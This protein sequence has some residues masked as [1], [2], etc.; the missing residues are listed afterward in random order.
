MNRGYDYSF[1]KPSP[2]LVTAIHA[3]HRVREEL[4]PIMSISEKDRLFEE[5]AAT[6]KIIGA[7]PN[8]IWG[9]DS[10]AEYDLNRPAALA[11]PLTA[12]RFWGVDVYRTAPG[13]QARRRSLAKYRAFYRFV[14]M[15]V[16]TLIGQFGCCIVHDIHS[17]NRS[18][19]IARGFAEP[20]V[21]NVGTT[22]AQRDKYGVQI[23]A[24]IDALSRIVIPGV[25]VTVAENEVFKGSGEFG[26]RLSALDDR[27]LVLS[28]EIAKVYMNEHTGELY[29]DRIDALSGQLAQFHL[30][31]SPA[32]CR[33]GE[34]NLSANR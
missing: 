23:D 25:A 18:R 24:W 21:F 29:H 31:P 5:D 2:V 32:I 27:I 12:E 28:T 16:K 22:L 26:R 19:Q 1:E 9:L 6:D 8:I 13:P 14:Q 11:L 10:R 3:G 30:L 7:C 33:M 15:R 34:N 20:P 4:A 17:Y